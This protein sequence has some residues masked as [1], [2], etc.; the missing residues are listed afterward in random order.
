MKLGK[1]SRIFLGIGILG[2]LA[3]SLSMAH[4]Q[5][6]KEQNRLKGEVILAQQ[7]LKIFPAEQLASKKSE[8]ESHLARAELQLKATKDRLYQSLESI[9]ASDALFEI[10]KACHAE[11]TA[12]SSQCL[13]TKALEEVTLPVLMLTVRVEGEVFTLIDF[14]SKWTEKYPTGMVKSVEISVPEVTEEEAVMER[15]KPET[16]EE[17]PSATVNLLLYSYKGD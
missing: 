13:T 15:P 4:N 12:I 1:V 8:L 7:R 10:A 3:V 16:E 11:I 14:I 9:E 6:S 2:I 17:K 5:Q